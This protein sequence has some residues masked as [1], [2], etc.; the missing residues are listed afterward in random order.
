MRS[1][2]AAARVAALA[3][4]L[5]ACGEEPAASRDARLASAQPAAPVMSVPGTVEVLNGCGAPGA[6]ERMR[7]HLTARGFDVLWSSNAED[8]NYARTMVAV[9]TPG[10]EGTNR[11]AAALKTDRVVVLLNRN[12][13]VDATVFIGHDYQEIINGN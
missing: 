6:A 10:W 11:L 4:L 7:R 1:A 12:S 3:L 2:L 9:R 13:T 5:S 8:A